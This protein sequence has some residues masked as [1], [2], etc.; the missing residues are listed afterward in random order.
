MVLGGCLV[1]ALASLAGAGAAGRRAHASDD[2]QGP[3]L[4]ALQMN[5]CDSGIADCYTGRSVR[6]AGQVIRAQRPGV[7]TLNEICRDDLPPLEQAMSDGGGVVAS[8]FEAA[9][10]QRTGGAYRCRNGQPYGIGVL[11]RLRPGQS[12]RTYSDVYPVQEAGDPEQR[13]WLC[14]HAVAGFYACTTH[15]ASGSTTVARDQCTYL[16][17][18]AVPTVRT[19]GGP[20]PLLLGADLNLVDG[21]SDARS[22]LTPGYQHADDGSRQ[23]VVATPGFTVASRKSIS[24]RGTTDHPALRVD[25]SVG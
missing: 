20:D 17:R 18:T 25:L 22:C 19:Q 15:L 11:A 21:S 23:Y 1:W 9:I 10:D 12:Y 8:A 7:V 16:L 4:R 2:L 13:V 5:L 14:L 3:T 6:R 24:M